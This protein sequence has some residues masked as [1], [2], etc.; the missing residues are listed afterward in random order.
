MDRV[1]ESE[2]VDVPIRTTSARDYGMGP[3]R[4]T[5]YPKAL[6]DVQFITV[7][8]VDRAMLVGRW[9]WY[10]PAHNDPEGEGRWPMTPL[11]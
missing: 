4:R 10:P 6:K 7:A 11:H 2:L 8:V 9:R 1:S 3:P 5:F